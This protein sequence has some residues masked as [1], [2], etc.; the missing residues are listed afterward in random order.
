M[1]NSDWAN[2]YGVRKPYGSNGAGTGDGRDNS[3]NGSA[4]LSADHPLVPWKQPD[5]MNQWVDVDHSRDELDRFEEDWPS[6]GELLD[7]SSGH[8][9]VVVVSGQPGM[10]KTSLI[11]RCIH[12]A[13]RRVAAAAPAAGNPLVLFA[14]T[15][16]LDNDGR[17]IS[18]DPDGRSFA[19]TRLINARI[20][21][22]IA[23]KLL[24]HEFSESRVQAIIAEED[25]FQ[26]YS[27]MS[28]LLIQHNAL[29]FVVIPHIRWNDAHLRAAF[30]RTCLSPAHPRIV[31]FVEVSHGAAETPREVTAA[32]S[33]SAAVTHLALR[34][35][36]SEDI[37]RFS[38]S[39]RAADGGPHGLVEPDR[40]SLMAAHDEWKP[41]DVREL[42]KVFHS[43]A[44]A[45]RGAPHPWPI[46]ADALR[47]H[48]ESRRA[49]RDAL[50][51][52]PILPRPGG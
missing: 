29:L 49:R 30:L 6:L 44:N 2:P 37:W 26:A 25:P 35:L 21:R 51:R 7:S 23:K 50:L 19:P 3:A 48:W 46:D 40:S 52:E 4:A 32:L 18:V 36:D 13:R 42:R 20:R 16:G 17:R 38:H 12:E 43:A 1:T 27:E 22:E 39:A 11:H 47:P 34:E 5:H 31:L 41:S 10:G 24:L 14:P 45:L 9:R 28:D 8:G 33:G 15:A